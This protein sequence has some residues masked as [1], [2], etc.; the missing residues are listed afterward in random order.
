MIELIYFDNAATTFPKPNAVINAVT[1][2]TRRRCGNPGRGG[3]ALARAADA[4]VY[5]CRKAI[6][7]F[8]NAPSTDSV[9]F[10]NNTTAALN[11][12]IFGLINSGDRV[13]TTDYE[14]NSVRRPLHRLN[15]VTVRKANTDFDNAGATLAE[16]KRMLAEGAEWLVVSH[17]SNVCG[18]TIPLREICVAAHTAGTRVIVDAAQSAGYLK[19]DVDADGIDYLCA[20]GHKGLY[21]PQGTGFIIINGAAPKPLLVGGTGSNSL[22]PDQPD[23][24]PDALES[25]T[26]N[27]PAISGLR[28]GISYLNSIGAENLHKREI[29]LVQRAYRGLESINGVILYTS[30]PSLNDS[31]VFSFNL[32]GKTSFE[33]ARLYDSY[34]ICL[35]AGYHC[36]PDAHAKLGTSEHGTVRLSV[37]AFN[38]ASE[39]DYFLRIT[40]KILK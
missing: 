28:E 26:L 30:A 20:P 11:T 3:H 35:R 18:K 33:A 27:V 22:S 7:E 25:G 16:F 29:S 15:G 8:F 6:K 24:T 37:G 36:A 34:G 23:Y 21:G 14:H 19:I 9:V 10:T 38:S 17:A 13:I 2:T 12:C 5:R 39:I 31:P 32:K 40:Q 4:E 1:D